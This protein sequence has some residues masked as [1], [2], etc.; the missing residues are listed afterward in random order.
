MGAL[1]L[2]HRS[3][4][5]PARPNYAR[6]H[7][8]LLRQSAQLAEARAPPGDPTL[9]LE[10]EEV[11]GVVRGVRDAMRRKGEQLRQLRQYRDALGAAAR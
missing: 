4:R 3:Q 2:M 7:A 9:E 10:R 1:F 11:A 6:R 8:A 5:P